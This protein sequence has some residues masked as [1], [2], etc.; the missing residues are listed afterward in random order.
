MSTHRL[1]GRRFLP[2]GLLAAFLPGCSEPQPGEMAF[3]AATS[4]ILRSG[5]EAAFGNNPDSQKLAERYNTLIRSKIA[6]KDGLFPPRKDDFLTYC[7]LREDRV[8]FLV[9][10]PLLKRYQGEARAAL[11][12]LAW[13]SAA[14]VT[15]D[16]RRK[17]D[18]RIG[19]GLRG[20]F[21]Y[22]G[23]AIG[24][25]NEEPRTQQGSLVAWEVLY[26]FFAEA[27]AAGAPSSD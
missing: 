24:M 20:S 19:V 7:E 9:N 18:R 2:V 23:L 5:K 6:E 21:V 10:V 14:S 12:Q 17:K 25:G 15:K 8:C 4:K 3:D 26:D 11:I 1:G 27:G 16:L 13:T 22:G